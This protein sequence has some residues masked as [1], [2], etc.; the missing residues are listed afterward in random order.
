MVM[1]QKFEGV[2]HDFYGFSYHVKGIKVIAY[3]FCPICILSPFVKYLKL[4]A[5][6]AN[7]YSLEAPKPNNTKVNLIFPHFLS[8]Q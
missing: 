1:L 8:Q 5:L 4:G 7:I 6:F 3:T 2:L